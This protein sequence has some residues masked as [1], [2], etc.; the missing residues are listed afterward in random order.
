MFWFVFSLCYFGLLDFVPFRAVLT[1]V[2]FVLLS[3][4]DFL[5]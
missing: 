4:V 5:F 2:Y 1:F 3:S